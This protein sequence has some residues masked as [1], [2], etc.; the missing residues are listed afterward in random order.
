[1]AHSTLV[2]ATWDQLVKIVGKG[3]SYEIVVDGKSLD[4]ATVVAVAR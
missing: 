2:L 3:D 1:M 4:L